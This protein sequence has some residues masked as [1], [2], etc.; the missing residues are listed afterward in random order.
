MTERRTVGVGWWLLSVLVAV[1]LGW[2]LAVRTLALRVGEA[3]AV[4]APALQGGGEAVGPA[5]K[6][7][8]AKVRLE[9]R[10]EDYLTV[11]EL[12]KYLSTCE[13]TVR[14]EIKEGKLPSIRMRG[15]V[16]VKGSDALAWLS[17]RKES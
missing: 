5:V 9:D 3:A 13:R 8:P 4:M 2:W 10:A 1:V 11:K 15:K 14:R 17:A 16:T 12:A 7:L 6:K